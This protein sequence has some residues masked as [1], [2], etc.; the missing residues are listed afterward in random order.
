[1]YNRPQSIRSFKIKCPVLEQYLP[2]LFSSAIPVIDTCH[3]C[4]LILTSTILVNLI[5]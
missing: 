5:I 3:I 4:K 1:M 2:V